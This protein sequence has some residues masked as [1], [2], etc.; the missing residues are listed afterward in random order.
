MSAVSPPF[1]ALLEA[2]DRIGS[3]VDTE[4][5]A[6]RQL[7]VVDLA[8]FNNRKSRGLLDLTRAF[9]ALE[10]E[11]LDER[12][13]ARLKQL[14]AKLEAN[15]AALSMHLAAAREITTIVAQS[16]RDSES[17]GT[18]SNILPSRAGNPW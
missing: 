12:A 15:Q 13:A 7:R 4:T 10:G 6:L 3:I 5:E 8:D 9:R 14:R 18:Y 2:M 16:I 17:D 11:R 1:G